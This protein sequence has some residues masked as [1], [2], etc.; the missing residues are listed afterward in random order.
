MKEKIK[1]PVGAPKK[2]PTIKPNLR[3]RKDY[4]DEMKAKY[5][6]QVN[7]MFNEWLKSKL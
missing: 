2:E 1:R 4:W 3:C 7:K 5:Q 6:S